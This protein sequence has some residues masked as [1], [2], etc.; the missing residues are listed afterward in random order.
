[1]NVPG[2]SPW[3]CFDSAAWED[4]ARG[5]PA[6]FYR[7]HQCVYPPG[8]GEGLYLVQSGRVRIEL[9]S[10]AGECKS[11]YIA[12]PGCLFGELS[13]LGGHAEACGATAAADS[14]VCCIP[15]ERVLAELE[16]NT[17]LCRSLLSL[18]ARKGSLLCAQIGQL[19]F[20][21]S[22]QRVCA[23]LVHLARR[24]GTPD[25]PGYRLDVK[26]THPEMGELVGLSRVSVSG[27]MGELLAG[28]LVQKRDGYIIIP[29][30]A[31]LQRRAKQ[32]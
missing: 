29:D 26:F 1:M 5:A 28:G 3:I 21:D 6:R 19:C 17:A 27:V 7:K 15:R 9:Y 22:V 2:N 23:A 25:G 31:L 30:I 32:R 14:S 16:G 10:G 20:D 13:L 18:L 11:L 8:G 12:E 24:H 4:I